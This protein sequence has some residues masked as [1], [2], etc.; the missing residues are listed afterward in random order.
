[1]GG[2]QGFSGQ[3]VV[4]LCVCVCVYLVVF[5]AHRGSGPFV[6]SA[7]GWVLQP[8]VTLFVTQTALNEIG[9]IQT[10]PADPERA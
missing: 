8:T 1:M 2:Q 6:G 3:G 7:R 5:F 4:A 10:R 9:A